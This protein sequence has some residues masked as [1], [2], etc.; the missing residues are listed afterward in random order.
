MTW[1]LAPLCV[2]FHHPTRWPALTPI[3]VLLLWD[4]T[5]YTVAV[6]EFEYKCKALF[7]T[8]WSSEYI[9]RYHWNTLNEK[10]FF[11]KRQFCV[12]LFTY[13]TC[14]TF[15]LT[16][17]APLALWCHSVSRFPGIKYAHT[18]CITSCTHKMLA[19]C[20][21]ILT[22]SVPIKVQIHQYSGREYRSRWN[23]HKKS[24]AATHTGI[25]P[26][27]M[28]TCC[29]DIPCQKMKNQAVIS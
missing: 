20:T 1:I 27:S 21:I 9:R 17:F 16:F 11:F 4:T 28:I 19:S 23:I 8:V 10:T 18:F 7:R 5:V 14:L 22:A 25:H 12:Y 24:Y 26:I 29:E 6:E 13:W 15:L 3:R 2:V